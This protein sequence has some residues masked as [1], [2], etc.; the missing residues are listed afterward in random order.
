M[1]YLDCAS[2][3]LKICARESNV[4]GSEESLDRIRL[5]KEEG[6][7]FFDFDFSSYCRYNLV[8][9]DMAFFLGSRVEPFVYVIHFLSHGRNGQ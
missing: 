6:L 8:I 2:P 3:R 5:Y 9:V 4:K 1:P 7:A